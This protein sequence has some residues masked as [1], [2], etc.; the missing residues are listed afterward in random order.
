MTKP[1]TNEQEIIYSKTSIQNNTLGDIH[2]Y[3]FKV[4]LFIATIFDL[5]IYTVHS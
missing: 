3:I 2:F 5:L 1:P 4:H